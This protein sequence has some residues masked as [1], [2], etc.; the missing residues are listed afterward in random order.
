GAL[1]DCSPIHTEVKKCSEWERIQTKKRARLNPKPIATQPAVIHRTRAAST[2][3][4]PQ[5]K[6]Q[7]LRKPRRRAKRL[8]A[9]SRTA[10]PVVS[11]PAGPLLPARLHSNRCSES[12]A[13]F[14][15]ASIRRP[16][17]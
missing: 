13:A 11:L 3:H 12:M 10:R 7:Q 1:D 17:H 15:A 14:Q 6:R 5:P 16:A 2:K 4:A 8:R 9:R